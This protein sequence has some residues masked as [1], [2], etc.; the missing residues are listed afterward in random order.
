ML[1]D[2][3]DFRSAVIVVAVGFAVSVLMLS[4]WKCDFCVDL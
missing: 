1:F 4:N 3:F 2:D